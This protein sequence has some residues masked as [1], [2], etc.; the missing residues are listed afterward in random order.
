M[1]IATFGGISISIIS[2]LLAIYYIIEHYFLLDTHVEGWTTLVVLQLFLSGVILVS[3]GI[4]GEYL[5]RAY[6]LS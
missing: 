5:G 2:L 3:L 4:V 6:L 1:R